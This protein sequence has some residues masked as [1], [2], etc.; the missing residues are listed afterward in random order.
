[1]IFAL[2]YFFDCFVLIVA[3][4]SFRWGLPLVVLAGI[5]FAISAGSQ[6]LTLF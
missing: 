6:L 5:A 1:M 3:A 4:L 2:V